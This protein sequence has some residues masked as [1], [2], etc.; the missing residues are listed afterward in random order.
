MN[1]RSIL[2]R[3]MLAGI[4]VAGIYFGIQN[5]QAAISVGNLN[6]DPVTE[7]EVRFQ[8]VKKILPFKRGVIGF[9]QNSDV[10][11]G[12]PD[13]NEQGEYT[14]TQYAM[15][16][17]ILV[18][19]DNEPWTLAIFNSKAFQ[20]WGKSNRGQFRVIPLNDNLYLFQRLTP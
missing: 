18:R 5:L 20:V 4:I 16:P 10:L 14:L 15:S 3:L 17:I 7:W 12:S 6:S 19:G 2:Q 13:S 11:G 9:L 8:P 1:I